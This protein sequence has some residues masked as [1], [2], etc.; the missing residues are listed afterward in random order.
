[1]VTAEGIARTALVTGAAR[2]IG[3]AVAERLSQDG[4]VVAALD[5]N[6]CDATVESVRRG[7]GSAEQYR[8][9]VRDWQAVASTVAEIERRQGPIGVV[10]S[11]AGIWEGIAFLELDPQSWHRLLDVNLTGSFNVC[12]QAAASMA[13]RGSG[14][15]VC[16][17]SNAA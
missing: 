3:A 8:C 6:D 2:G 15:I 11:V 10:A 16:V 13:E 14:S 12:R 9:D 7:G 17:A 4:L 5:V 1:V